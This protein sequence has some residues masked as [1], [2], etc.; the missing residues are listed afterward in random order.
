MILHIL[1]TTLSCEIAPV[2]I[3]NQSNS[4]HFKKKGDYINSFAAI[5]YA[6]G[7]LDSGARLGIFKV[8]DDKLFTIR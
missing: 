3:T 4:K 5:N 6:H 7:W 8:K 2:N 1:N